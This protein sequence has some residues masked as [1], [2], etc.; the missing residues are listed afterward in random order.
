VR[1]SAAL[2][3]L[4]A[5]LGKSFAGG[6]QVDRTLDQTLNRHLSQT[7]KHTLDQIRPV[8]QIPFED[9]EIYLQP[10]GGGTSKTAQRGQWQQKEVA[11]LTLRQGCYTTED[12]SVFARL[13]RHS[14]LV[15]LCGA[16]SSRSDGRSDVLVTELARLGSL[17]FLLGQHTS[18]SD[19]V[20]LRVAMQVVTPYCFPAS[21]LVACMLPFHYIL[22]IS[23]F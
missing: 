20:L 15:S 3:T 4:P 16:S 18:V 19:A 9:L 12:T 22:R 2:H 14:A 6:E 17:D 5:A 10:I 13:G 21:V 7:L 1:I 11:V 8:N 23:Y